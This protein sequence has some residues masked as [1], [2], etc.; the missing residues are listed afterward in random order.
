MIGN[1]SESLGTFKKEKSLLQLKFQLAKQN[2]KMSSFSPLKYE[3]E[4][5]ISYQEALKSSL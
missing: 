5:Q 2:L 1:L 4:E 3:A